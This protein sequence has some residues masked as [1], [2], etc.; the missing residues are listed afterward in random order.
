MLRINNNY[1]AWYEKRNIRVY[2]SQW[3]RSR[4]KYLVSTNYG[5]NILGYFLSYWRNYYFLF[6]FLFCFSFLFH[7]IAFLLSRCIYFYYFTLVISVYDFSGIKIIQ[8][9]GSEIGHQEY[10]NIIQFVDSQTRPNFNFVLLFYEICGTSY[11]SVSHIV[12]SWFR[13]E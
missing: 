6:P 5:S 4:S 10:M 11:F 3:R 8:K 13:Y 1:N 2:T 9:L 7:F 12:M